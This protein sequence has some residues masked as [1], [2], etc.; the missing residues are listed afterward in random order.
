MILYRIILHFNVQVADWPV[1]VSLD[2]CSGVDVFD[3]NAT[4]TACEAGPTSDKPLYHRDKCVM[5]RFVFCGDYR[6]RA[7]LGNDGREGRWLDCEH[8]ASAAKSLRAPVSILV[9]GGA[10][11]GRTPTGPG[12]TDFR[13]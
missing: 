7:T 11:P 2:A 10:S 5:G 3:I 12:V 6:R 8:E 13:G 4:V 9:P 1:S